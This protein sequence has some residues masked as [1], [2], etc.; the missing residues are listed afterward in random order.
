MDTLKMS[1][2]GNGLQ[3]SGRRSAAAFCVSRWDHEHSLS[4]Y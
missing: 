2:P 1:E 3:S 4:L